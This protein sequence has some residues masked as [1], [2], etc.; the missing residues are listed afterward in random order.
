MNRS[1]G[2]AHHRAGRAFVALTV[3]SL[4]AACTGSGAT[5]APTSV[6]P[7]E[8]STPS[9]GPNARATPFPSPRLVDTAAFAS[10]SEDAVSEER[11]ARFQAILETMAGQGGVTATVMTLQGMW[12]GAAGK[13]DDVRDVVVD[14]QFGIASVTK[15]VIAAQVMQLVEAGELSLDEPATDHLPA[16]FAFDTNGATIRQLLD[17]RSGIPDWYGEAMQA[18]V[19][20]NRTRV[21]KPADVLALVD[22]ARRAP[23]SAFEYADTNYTLLGLVIE[24]VRQR[25]LVDVLRDGVLRVEGTERLI[26]QPAEAPSDPMAM[27]L[28]ESRDALEKGGGYLPSLSDAS[29]GG[30]AGGMASDSI[31]LA[32]WWRAFCAGEIVSDASLT[33]MSTFDGGPDGY[34]LGLFNP[35]VEWGMPGVG[36]SGGNFG[37]SSWTGCMPGDHPFV[38]VVLT[39]FWVDDLWKLPY[40]LVMAARSD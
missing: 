38:L 34:G 28:G 19:A 22:P 4:V 6:E 33:E 25:P 16:D 36:H 29:S 40:P 7:S 37:Y 26:Y 20:K 14:S 13:A 17:M 32:R 9:A 18:E 12:S 21:W 1:P 23:G 10:M 39:N 8:P 31:S 5:V 15:P 3:T 30:P 24:H 27:P 35:V 11:A 2:T